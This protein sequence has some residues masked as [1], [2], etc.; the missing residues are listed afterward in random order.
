MNSKPLKTLSHTVMATVMSTLLAGCEAVSYYSQMAAGHLSILSKREAVENVI[1]N[2]DTPA[3]LKDKLKLTQ[4]AREFAQ[5]HLGLSA[6]GHYMHY[7]ALDRPYVIWNVFA[8]PALSV[9]AKKWCYPIIGCMVYRGYYSEQNAQQYAKSLTDKGWDIYVGGVAAYSTLGWFKD[10]ILSTFMQRSDGQ[11]VDLIFHELAHQR[12]YING[13]ST[14]NESF[15]TVV[16]EEGLKRWVTNKG[17]PTVYEQFVQ[18]QQ[19]HKQFTE[20]VIEY[21]AKLH[22][23]YQSNLTPDQKLEQKTEIIAA[24]RQA[25]EVIKTEQW[26]G[27]RGYD[28]WF[29]EDINNAKLVTIATYHSYVPKLAEKLNALEGNMEAFYAWCEEIGKLSNSERKA[30]LL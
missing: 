17:D 2:K 24:L 26:Q 11:L 12:L 9:S 13:D 16:A 3:K 18:R 29:S 14:F 5:V 7:V 1:A 22:D 30:L 28:R 20:L 27:Y 21:R 10:P 25:Y 19:R 8:A 23:L 15:A 4:A 6:D